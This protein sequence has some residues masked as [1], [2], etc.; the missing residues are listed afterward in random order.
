MRHTSLIL[1]AAALITSEAIV[2]ATSADKVELWHR[3]EMFW[4]G[5]IDY[6]MV[7]PGPNE[8]LALLDEND[9]SKD[10]GCYWYA[11]SIGGPEMT[12]DPQTK[13]C[14]VYEEYADLLATKEKD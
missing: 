11:V 5:Q 4:A 3:I 7:S 13:Q 10:I 9:M 2:A 1:S 14:I 6:G 12:W 8:L